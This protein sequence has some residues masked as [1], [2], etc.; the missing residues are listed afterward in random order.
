VKPMRYE[1]P[2]C[3]DQA[4]WDIWLSA[5]RL[6]AMSVAE[7]LGVFE[8]LA[9]GPAA[10]AEIAQRLGLNR[11]ASA[12]LLSMLA[13]LGLV[14]VRDARY[15][16]SDVTRTFL[17]PQSQYYWGPLLRA[18]G[19]SPQQRAALTRA[20]RAADD[21]PAPRTGLPSGL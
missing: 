14:E 12:V 21:T 9:S 10:A 17:L 16:I 20:L 11:Q 6:P 8:I 4:I 15:E 19:A 2:R 3:Q 7:E 18:V 13:A 5:H 1:L